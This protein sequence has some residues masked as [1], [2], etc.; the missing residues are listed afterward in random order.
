MNQK[1]RPAIVKH[2]LLFCLVILLFIGVF[3]A[4]VDAQ[5]FN[6]DIGSAT[7]DT[8]AGSGIASASFT[9]AIENQ[10]NAPLEIA[11]YSLF[12]D[13][14]VDGLGLPVGVSFDTNNG[15]DDAVTYL[16]GG[17]QGGLL[18]NASTD[19][20]GATI[21]FTPAAGDLGLGQ[22][23]FGVNGTLAA[24]A[25]ADLLT[26][27]L[28]IDRSI[29]ETGDFTIVLSSDGQSSVSTAT[30]GS[31]AF[32]FTDGTLS[33]QDGPAFLLGDVNRDSTVNFLD[34]GPFVGILTAS[35]F[36]IEADINMDGVVNFLDIG[37]FVD[38]LTSQ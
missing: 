38:L 8:S 23:Q 36:Q 10:T 28:L 34:I 12:L 11:G 24:G 13:I 29:A 18:P 35:G 32:D 7:V 37:P 6:F 5:G 2:Q 31:P 27:N 22:L 21:N 20:P 25:S 4:H 30:G 9:I 1:T 15:G 16:T 19:P 3:T 17:G 14:G 33:I 26:V